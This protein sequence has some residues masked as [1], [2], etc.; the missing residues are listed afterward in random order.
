MDLLSNAV[1]AHVDAPSRDET[2]IAM[3]YG[4]PLSSSAYY[5]SA[6]SSLTRSTQ[7]IQLSTARLSSGNRLIN[8]GDDVAAL[9]IST[10]LQSQVTAIKAAQSNTAQASSFLQVAYGALLNVRDLLDSLQSLATQAN[11]GAITNTDRALLQVQFDEYSSEIDRIASNTKF[12]NVNLLDGTIS[13]GNIP[14]TTTTQATKASGTVTFTANPTAGQTVIL[15][16][17]T[18]TAAA[19]ASTST[20]FTIGGDSTTTATNLAAAL[21]AST[22]RAIS[23]ATYAGAGSGVTISHDSGGKLGN[24]YLIGVGTASYTVTGTATQSA[25]YYTLQGGLDNGLRTNSVQASGSIGDALVNTQ[26]QTSASTTLTIT[27]TISDTE[28]LTIDDGNA[29]AVTFTFKNSASTS[30]EIQIGSSTEETLQNAVK[31]ISQYSSSNNYGTRQLEFSINGSQ[32]VIRHK[33]VGNSAD[34]SGATLDITETL[35]NGSLTSATV[36]GGTATGV[37]TGGVNNSDFIGEIS[38]FTATYVGADSITA[39]LTVGDHT[40][41]SA[42]TD[43][44]PGSATNYRF[45]STNGGYFDVEIASGGFAVTNQSTADTFAARLD[46]AFSTLT[47]YQYRNMS[48]FSGVNGLAGATAEIKLDDFSNVSIRSISV[49]APSATDGTIDITLRNNGAEEIFRASSG[50]GGSIG[51][52][53]T[54]TLTSLTDSNRVIRIT[55]GATVNSFATANA[56]ETFA[57]ALRDS[58]GLTGDGEGTSFQVGS[59]AEDVISVRIDDASTSSLFEGETPDITTQGNAE[60]AIATL[61]SALDNLNTIIS[62]VGSYQARFDAASTNLE[63]SRIYVDEARSKLADTD[64]AEEGT[65]LALA[66]LRANAATALIAQT[67]RLQSSLLEMLKIAA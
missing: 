4:T 29:S 12:N 10:K 40:Y 32:L 17:V 39:S 41:T 27:G 11:S 24:Q 8:A 67:S 3:P 47:F 50:V 13:G 63:N 44:T 36:S 66:T 64:V 14:T 19:S 30:T 55:N 56:A 43:T 22:N 62:D 59:S 28:T 45:S 23:Q 1:W 7:Q 65:N 37:N 42:I 53:E 49:T 57:T 25:S 18:F 33:N 26:S 35:A 20:E 5:G 2:S 15:N 38:G 21:N 61:T 16:G 58:F 54:L 9:S 31:T 51:R 6:L 48:S 60:D 46:A 34:F 52:Y